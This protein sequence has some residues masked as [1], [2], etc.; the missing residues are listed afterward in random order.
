MG[1]WRTQGCIVGYIPGGVYPAP[2]WVGTL[3]PAPWWVGTLL[4]APS[5][6][7]ALPAPSGVY[8]FPAPCVGVLPA[9]WVGVLPAPER[10]LSCNFMSETGER[11]SER[12]FTL[13]SERLETPVQGPWW[14]QEYQ[15]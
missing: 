8:A 3:L 1:Q 13:L 2:W 5:G 12:G 14:E 10:C 15:H 11:G 7:Y 4:P 9:P 6:V